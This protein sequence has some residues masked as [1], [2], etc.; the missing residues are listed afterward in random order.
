MNARMP[1]VLRLTPLALAITLLG[2]CATPPKEPPAKPLTEKNRFSG[3]TLADLETRQ[4]IVEAE[5]IAPQSAEEVLGNYQTALSLFR[6]PAARLDTLRRMAELTMETSQARDGDDLPASTTVAAGES[7]EVLYERFMQGMASSRDRRPA[8]APEAVRPNVNYAEAVKLYEQ[9]VRDAPVGPARA[10]AYYELAKAYDMNSQRAESVDVLRKLFMEYPGSHFA[11]EAQFR[12]AEYEFSTNRFAAAADNYAAVVKADDN[13]EF[14]DQALYKQ[15]W[16]LYKASDYEAAQPLFFQVIEE[17]QPKTKSSDTA[18][19]NVLKIL[20]D[21]YNI[22]SLGFIQQD[23]PRSV[24]AYFKKTGAKDYEADVYM[25]LGHTYLSKRLYRNAAET[26]DYFVSKYPFDARAPEFS[27]A[28]IRAYQDGGFPSEVIPAKENFVKRYGPASE[29]WAKADART[30]EDMLPLLQSHIID[31]AKHQHAVAQQSKKEED[32]LKAASW[33]RQHLA[34]NPPESEAITINQLLAEALFAAKKF[35]DAIIEFEKTAYSYP[36]NP[37]PEEAAYFALLAYLEQEPALPS[38]SAEAQ[39]SWWDRRTASTYKYA[40]K[41]PGN[42]N[43][44]LVLQGLTNDQIAAKDVAGAMK[45]AGIILQL[46]PPAPDTI[47]KESWM[48]I[49]DGE[50]DLNRPEAAEFA[51]NKVLAYNDLTPEQ[52][53]TYQGRLTASVYKQA[54]KLRDSKDVD[55]AVAAYLRAASVSPDPKL[56][57]GA[58]FDA[59]TMYLNA[60]R[61][62]EAIPMLVA[63]RNNY[64]G[65][66]LNDTIPEK[67][68]LS[69]EKT[70]QLDRAAAEYEGI[71]ARNLKTEPELARQAL[72]TAAEMYDKAKRGDESARV[73]RQYINSFP[74]PLDSNMEAQFRLYNHFVAGGN[75]TESQNMLRELSRSFDRAGADNTARTSYL[76]AMAKFRLN[77][78]IYDEFAAIQL[79]QPLKKSLATKRAAM[80][81]ALD[82]YS[83]VAS[84]GVAE[85]TTASNYQIAEIYRKLAADLM[86]SERPKGLSEL[87]LEQYSILLEEQA[88]PFE[89]KALDLYVANAEL[90]KQNVYDDFVRQ[91]LDALAKLSPGRYNKREQSETYVDVIY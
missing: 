90:V 41:F 23:G 80:Q 70:G 76:G 47:I 49:A 4:I 71:S 46:Q 52:R 1:L 40:E 11:T 15:A 68:A 8:K 83:R 30:R 34:L 37:K 5:E 2:G 27:S 72:W 20:D 6:D 21:T 19:E 66:E 58:E 42:T 33:Y 9:V 62:A 56:K 79:R 50:F 86:A 57:A 32:Y 31:L 81:K 36:G 77:Q 18:S 13:A 69:Y 17:W 82:A 75:T 54:E 22:I 85:F 55:G 29:F 88:T 60:E 53:K 28:T 87:E 38:M 45:T 16:S 24:D 44:P 65:N 73:Y 63:F 14:R 51:Y 43:T 61:H 25:N 7:E 35:D 39:K 26:F 84:I 48:V 74:K 12:V 78:P 64:P 59:A 10:N 67:L 3:A 91:S 89:D